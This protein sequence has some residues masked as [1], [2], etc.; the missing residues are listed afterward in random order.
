MYKVPLMML[1]SRKLWLRKVLATTLSQSSGFARDLPIA[2][3]WKRAVV[4]VQNTKCVLEVHLLK[5]LGGPIKSYSMYCWESGLSYLLPIV[6]VAT[7]ECYG[8][9]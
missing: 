3:A 4:V 1:L 5:S 7:K 9:A 6:T 8:V 2:K